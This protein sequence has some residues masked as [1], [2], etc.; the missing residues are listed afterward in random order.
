[1]LCLSHQ[2]GRE[3]V[4][5][6]YLSIIEYPLHGWNACIQPFENLIYAFIGLL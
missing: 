4:S 2:V 1:M 5:I 6:K 3:A